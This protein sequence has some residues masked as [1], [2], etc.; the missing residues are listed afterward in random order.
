MRKGRAR[1][2]VIFRHGTEGLRHAARDPQSVQR[3]IL[4]RKV[5]GKGIERRK[6][7][8]V[9]DAAHRHAVKFRAYGNDVRRRF[10]RVFH[11]RL[12]R[13]LYRRFRPR[14]A[15]YR[16]IERQRARDDFPFRIQN[17]RRSGHGRRT[18]FR[19]LAVFIPT[20]EFITRSG[21][22]DAGK[23]VFEICAVRY[24]CFI[25]NGRAAVRDKHDGEAADH[26]LRRDGRFARIR[27]IVAH[28]RDDGVVAR[29]PAV[30]GI[31]HPYRGNEGGKGRHLAVFHFHHTVTDLR[32]RFRYGIRTRRIPI[33][34]NALRHGFGNG[35]ISVFARVEPDVVHL[36]LPDGD[37]VKRPRVFSAQ[38]L[39]ELRGVIG[40]FPCGN[41]PG[42]IRAACAGNIPLHQLVSDAG[43]LGEPDDR[44]RVAVAVLA[45]ICPRA[46]VIGKRAAV[47]VKGNM[48]SYFTDLY[49]QREGKRA[50]RPALLP[51]IFRDRRVDVDR[52]RQIGVEIKPFD[53]IAEI[54]P[55]PLIRPAQIVYRGKRSER[56]AERISEPLRRDRR[57]VARKVE[58]GNDFPRRKDG[59]D[60]H[61]AR[62]RRIFHR[63]F[64]AAV[65]PAIF[66]SIAEHL[67]QPCILQER[68]IF[69]K[70]L[71]VA[72]DRPVHGDGNPREE[73][74]VAP[75]EVDRHAVFF[76]V[77]R[78]L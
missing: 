42:G 29:Q 78:E 33:E 30:K 73:F 63:K 51:H 50:L 54:I 55:A 53:L 2:A 64:A 4:P 67:R 13:R 25:R 16:E 22:R 76:I 15:F 70:R 28:R 47:A 38:Q 75:D 31:A 35:E 7:C 41:A 65:R 24:A 17:E 52:F 71:D 26:P 77:R 3:I 61:C 5:Y 48:I 59:V 32:A 45:G 14:D 44:F 43:R 11:R 72:R 39:D 19:P 69:F 27:R 18:L 60:H 40:R 36:R 12:Y 8:A 1:F 10:K 20:K 62:N 66:K 68:R 46:A 37:G 58:G 34:C 6:R 23:F 9:C 21:G 74:A 56:R 57:S 49:I